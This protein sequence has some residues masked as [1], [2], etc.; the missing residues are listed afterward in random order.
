MLPIKRGRKQTPDPRRPS[1]GFHHKQLSEDI[2]LLSSF[3]IPLP[4]GLSILLPRHLS[5]GEGYALL[6]SQPCGGDSLTART[7][8]DA[9]WDDFLSS[10]GGDEEGY[11]NRPRWVPEGRKG[12]EEV[13]K[14]MEK[15]GVGV[16]ELK[17]VLERLFVRG[18]AVT[19]DEGLVKEVHERHWV[20]FDRSSFSLLLPLFL[21]S[22][23]RS[24]TPFGAR[25]T[26]PNCSRSTIVCAFVIPQR[27]HRM[28]DH[29]RHPFARVG[30]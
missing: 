13:K 5:V 9:L 24:L 7:A 10:R 26:S 20:W 19:V 2:A 27:A 4:S 11:R 18:R 29:S 1:R 15:E 8:L 22:S 6:T 17:E 23:P 16:R 28:S 30:R 14:E 12:W 25:R 21:S 3:S